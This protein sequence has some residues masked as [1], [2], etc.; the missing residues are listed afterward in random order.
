MQCKI[1]AIGVASNNIVHYATGYV[2]KY[3][4]GMPIR[5]V[6]VP[7][8][9]TCQPRMVDVGYVTGKDM[10]TGQPLMTAVVD[11]LTSPLTAEEKM[12]GAPSAEAAEPRLLP[13]DSEENLRQ[14]FDDKEWTDFN[15]IILPTE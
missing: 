5:Y 10:L 1:P 7:F 8:P 9:F 12:S 2:A 11:A 14:L 13:P 4:T 6:F 3:Q 15:S